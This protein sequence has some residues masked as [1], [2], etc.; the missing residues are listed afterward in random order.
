M[1]ALDPMPRGLRLLVLQ[2]RGSRASPP[3]LRAVHNRRHHFQIPQQFSAGS[4]RS[5]L[6]RLPLRFEKQLGVVQ[7][8]FADRG[9]TFA[10]RDIQWAGW[11]R[12][13]V[14]LGEDP[15]HPLAVFQALAGH[16]H[17]KLHRHLRQDLALAHLLLDRFW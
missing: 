2:L 1:N 7:N 16:R 9:R 3:P 4:G 11:A 10:P 8:P 6:P 13:A 12:I 17:Q 5:F 15:R 14:I